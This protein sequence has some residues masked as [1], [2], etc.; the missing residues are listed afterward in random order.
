M[1]LNFELFDELIAIRDSLPKMKSGMTNGFVHFAELPFISLYP[2]NEWC[3]TP[4]GI[5]AYPIDFIIGC[6][7]FG[8][9]ANCGTH[10]MSKI[11][12][13][14]A[15]NRKYIH[16]FS[17]KDTD[18]I[19]YISDFIGAEAYAKH[20]NGLFEDMRKHMIGGFRWMDDVLKHVLCTAEGL[21]SNNRDLYRRLKLATGSLESYR[22]IP[23]S[24]SATLAKFLRSCGIHCII[25]TTGLIY[26]TEQEQIWVSST[27][28]FDHKKVLINNGRSL[29]LSDLKSRLSEKRTRSS[30]PIHYGLDSIGK[31]THK[32]TADRYVSEMVDMLV[33]HKDSLDSI[34]YQLRNMLRYWYDPEI[35]T[36]DFRALVRLLYWRRKIF[37]QFHERM[38]K[39]HQEII[40]F[41]ST[42][43]QCLELYSSVI[44]FTDND[45]FDTIAKEFKTCCEYLSSTQWFVDA[46]KI[47]S[48]R[49][50]NL[51]CFDVEHPANKISQM[52]RD[53]TKTICEDFY[54]RGDYNTYND[55]VRIAAHAFN[56]ETE[57]HKLLIVINNTLWTCMQRLM[58][59]MFIRP[60]VERQPTTNIATLCTTI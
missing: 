38:S 3:D 40:D 25:D 11:G 43:K 17:L 1:E 47:L 37:K 24:R 31:T 15:S 58:V 34:F 60:W 33:T 13:P 55:S 32:F 39:E 42:D 7:E 30:I 27:Q 45:K 36:G 6:I 51:N 4:T 5:Y 50:Q 9:S 53:R 20:T 46:Y 29:L 16:V 54:A 23:L 44:D 35:P 18:N 48:N 41:L 14:F 12:I 22:T 56:R 2:G 28:L 10:Y 19:L 57:T 49:G 21:A 26:S 52:M 59:N 8:K